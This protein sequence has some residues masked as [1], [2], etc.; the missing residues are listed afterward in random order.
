MSSLKNDIE[1]IIGQQ[2]TDMAGQRQQR[3]TVHI[4]HQYREFLEELYDRDSDGLVFVNHFGH[5][6]YHNDAFAK[7]MMLDKH[8]KP[9]TNI[10]AMDQLPMD[11]DLEGPKLQITYPNGLIHHH[12][13]SYD[14]VQFQKSMLLK[15]TFK[16]RT[17]IHR[18]ARALKDVRNIS[19]HYLTNLSLPMFLMDDKG[20]VEHVPASDLDVFGRPLVSLAGQSIFEALPF[21]YASELMDKAKNI[22]ERLSGHF[23]HRREV[24]RIVHVYDTTVRK[25][26]KGLFL[27]EIKDV[28]D[29][30][31][32]SST[33]EYLNSYDS[34]TGFYNINY[35]ENTL[36]SL[37]D[38]GQMPMGIYVLTLQ[39]L[40]Q[41]NIRMGYHQC[42]NLLID[43]ALNIRSTISQHEIPCRVTGDTYVVFFPNCSPERLD[44]FT[45]KM[46]GFID[47]YKKTYAQY[48]LTYVEKSVLIQSTLTDYDRI[49]KGLMV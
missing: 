11:F 4:S 34:L 8:K 1:K 10:Y 2:I 35:Y 23:M 33:I 14:C 44:G 41:V 5:I 38:S 39:G 24:D 42:D 26:A 21:D 30:N 49:V 36:A 16:E 18:S 20:I 17:E 7:I 40:K 6:E 43:I 22:T 9:F 48:C 19:G 28:S 47:H 31:T 32:M 13:F 37:K 25:V 46:S 15:L 3:R 45:K 29:L 12:D 27:C